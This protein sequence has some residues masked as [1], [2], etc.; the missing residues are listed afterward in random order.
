MTNSGNLNMGGGSITNVNSARTPFALT[1]VSNNVPI[2]GSTNCLSWDLT[3]ASTLVLIPCDSNLEATIRVTV[4]RRG[5]AFSI[6]TTNC[7]TNGLGNINLCTNVGNP[8]QT[9]L[10]NQSRWGTNQV[11]NKIG[12]YQLQ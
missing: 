4:D 8:I 3:N 1:G 9:F 2:C 5:F 11:I 6:A 10:F 7:I 12:G